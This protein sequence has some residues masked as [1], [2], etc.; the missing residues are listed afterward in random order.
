MAPILAVAE[1]PVFDVVNAGGGAEI[2]FVCEHAAKAIPA[3]LSSLGLSDAA[4]TSHVAW[5][6]G[7][8][9]VALDL[10]KAFDAPLVAARFSRLVYDCNRAPEAPDAVP[11][12]SESYDIPG[13]KGLDAAARAGRMEEFYAPFQKAL[14]QLIDAKVARGEQPAVVSVHSFTPTYFGTPREVELGILH[15][16]DTRLAD[17]LLAQAPVLTGLRT[18]RN[19]P[20]GPADGVTHTLKTHALPRGLPNAML[21][22]RNDLI[23]DDAACQRVAAALADLLQKG[24]SSLASP[25]CSADTAGVR[26]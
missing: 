15:D 19:A 4:R 25:L 23:G 7:A 26:E 18:Q 20:Y 22:I 5:D 2:V 13:N 3:A 9:T 24:M 11:E 16:A 12:R 10:S 6:P 14:A 1:G 8:L 17:A 21:E